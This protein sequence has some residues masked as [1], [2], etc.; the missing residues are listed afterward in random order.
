MNGRH[1]PQF[2]NTIWLNN[3][4]FSKNYCDFDT[5]YINGV[6]KAK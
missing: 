2:R 4:K 6:E 1:T 5:E 3:A